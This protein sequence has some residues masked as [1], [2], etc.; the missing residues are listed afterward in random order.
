MV[1]VAPY[2]QLLPTLSQ[3]P[4]KHVWLTYDA[5]GDVLYIHF[6]QPNLATDNELTDDDVIIRYSGDE[7]IGYTILHA[8][9]RT[10]AF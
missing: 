4:D 1:A 3:S 5:Q 6:K 8:S 10:P 7:I 2:L 9:K